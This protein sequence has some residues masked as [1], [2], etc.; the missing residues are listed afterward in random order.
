[1]SW[2]PQGP[3]DKLKWKRTKTMTELDTKDAEMCDSTQVMAVQFK[4]R[5]MT[6]KVKKKLLD[7]EIPYSQIPQ[8]DPALYKEAEEL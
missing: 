2:Q 5:V 3:P 4:K 7:K 8:K 6:D 1:M